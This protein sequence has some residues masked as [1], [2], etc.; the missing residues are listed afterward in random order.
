M[1]N[2]WIAPLVGGVVAFIGLL[3][4]RHHVI[5]WRTQKNDPELESGERQHYYARYRRRMQTSGLLALIGPLIVLSDP[6]ILPWR[7]APGWYGVYLVCLLCLVVWV[8]LQA[9]GDMASTKAHS[10][11]SLARIR[12]EQRELEQKLAELKSRRSNGRHA[13]D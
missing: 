2:P 7:K 13:D 9:V 10:R 5:R 1:N 11:V 12:R 4:M 6:E 8:I 3:M